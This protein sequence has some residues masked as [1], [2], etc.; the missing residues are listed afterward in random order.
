MATRL[1]DMVAGRP[2]ALAEAV[3]AS[4]QQIWQAGLGAF[5]KAQQEGGGMFDALVRE[6]EELHKLT[7]QAGADKPGGMADRVDRLA[8]NV[9]RQASGSWDRIETIFEDRVARAMRSLG[10]P[11]REEVDALRREIEA[12]KAAMAQ[13]APRVP[14]APSARTAAKPAAKTAAGTASRP[15]AKPAAKPAVKRAAKPAA[16]P[17]PKRSARTSGRHA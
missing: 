13:P 3:A 1:K 12:L 14:A 9:G 15:A 7:R 16:A 10:V 2:E 6:G 4:A 17:A 5:A 8:E 11:G